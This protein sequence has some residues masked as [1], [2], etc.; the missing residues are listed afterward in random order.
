M[1]VIV[2]NTPRDW[3]GGKNVNAHQANKKKIET[4]CDDKITWD[5][6]KDS[7]YL[8]ENHKENFKMN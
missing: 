3:G 7:E 2:H 6:N 1:S 8:R 5:Q 4:K